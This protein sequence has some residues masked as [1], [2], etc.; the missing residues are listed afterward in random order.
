MLKKVESL[1][2][3]QFNYMQMAESIG[4]KSCHLSTAFGALQFAL[5][6]SSNEEYNEYVALWDKWREK[7]EKEIWG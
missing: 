7:F 6:L 2:E 5:E 3:R 1:V 4:E